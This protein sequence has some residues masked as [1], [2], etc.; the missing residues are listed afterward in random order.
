LVRLDT[1]GTGTGNT[2]ASSGVAK[3]NPTGIVT[4]TTSFTNAS[5]SLTTNGIGGQCIRGGGTVVLT[6]AGGA[7]LYLEQVGLNCNTASSSVG[8]ASVNATFVIN[9]TLSTGRFAGATGTGTVVTGQ[10]GGT[11]Q[12]FLTIEGTI[13]LN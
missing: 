5:D 2:N 11:G 12:T 13:K 7:V 1:Q 6:T 9:A 3:G 10:Y 4:Y 8:D